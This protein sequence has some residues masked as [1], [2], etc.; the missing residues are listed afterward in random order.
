MLALGVARTR[1]STRA[2]RRS[3]HGRVVVRADVKVTGEYNE[4]SGQVSGPPPAEK[5]EA[6]QNADGTYYI[7]DL[8]AAEKPR[9]DPMSDDMKRKLRQ[10][11]VEL[12]GSANT[13]MANNYFLYIILGIAG[14]AISCKILGYI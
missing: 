14:L 13:P 11:Y 8:E 2:S 4:D 3:G 10:Q 12:G 7:D 5:K 6:K 1:I 9:K